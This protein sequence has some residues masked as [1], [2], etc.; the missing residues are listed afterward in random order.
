MKKKK[1][2]IQRV[3]I[4]KIR[5]SEVF[6]QSALIILVTEDLLVTLWQLIHPHLV[7]CHCNLVPGIEDKLF[8]TE[9]PTSHDN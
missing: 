5:A 6:L 4:K 2:N 3:N 9:Q 7:L 8:P 1:K